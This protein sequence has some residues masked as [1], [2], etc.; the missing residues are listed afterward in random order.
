MH[1]CLL[2][3]HKR[4]PPDIARQTSSPHIFRPSSSAQ[5]LPLHFFRPTPS[6]QLLPHQ[7]LPPNFRRASDSTRISPPNLFRNRSSAKF[8]QPNLF[9]RISYPQTSST[10]LILP[11]FVLQIIL[12]AGFFSQY[13]PQTGSAKVFH[14]SA[15]K[16][17][18]PNRPPPNILQQA[19]VCVWW[20]GAWAV[21]WQVGWTVG[22]ESGAQ[23]SLGTRQGSGQFAIHRKHALYC[24]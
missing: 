10:N 23:H 19:C 17:R 18:H 9:R 14:D 7:R 4:L 8:V 13:L 22:G 2:L 15:S 12:R 5:L 24:L 6:A 11:N 1:V 16:S 21:G 20:G 3:P